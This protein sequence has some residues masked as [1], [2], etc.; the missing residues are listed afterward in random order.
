LLA[1]AGI[2]PLLEPGY[3]VEWG[4]ARCILSCYII[5]MIRILTTI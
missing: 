5:T 4:C 3:E 2:H 1:R